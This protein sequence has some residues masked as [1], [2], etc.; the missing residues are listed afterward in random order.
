MPTAPRRFLISIAVAGFAE[1]DLEM[2]ARRQPA[3]GARP[4][5]G[6]R[7]RE[8]LH[9]GIAARQFQRTFLLAD[10][11]EIGEAML[12]HGMLTIAVV[13]PKA[14]RSPGESKSVLPR[15]GNKKCKNARSTTTTI[16]CGT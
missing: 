15:K 4:A 16:P 1:S 7:Q 3:A 12:K 10:G 11:V 8:Y 9:R 13:R 2:T 6:R 14:E 5:E